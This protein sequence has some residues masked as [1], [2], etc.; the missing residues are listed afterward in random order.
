M[1]GTWIIGTTKIAIIGAMAKELA[2]P[3]KYPIITHPDIAFVTHSFQ[4][5]LVLNCISHGQLSSDT[6]VCTIF[7]KEPGV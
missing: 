6:V 5:V 2:V 3:C 4:G 7:Q 1:F